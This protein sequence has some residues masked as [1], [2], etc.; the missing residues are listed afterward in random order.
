[1]KKF[2]RFKEAFGLNEYGLINFPRKI[3][4]VKIS[5][6]KIGKEQGCEWCFP[7]GYETINCTIPERNWKSYRKKQWKKEY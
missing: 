3:S 5:R 1:M 4:G 6:I 2:K 7:H